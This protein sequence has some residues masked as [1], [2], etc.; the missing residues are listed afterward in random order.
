MTDEKL[1]A[2]LYESV[3]IYDVP[4]EL[5]EYEFTKEKALGVKVLRD[6]AWGRF[7]V[8]ESLMPLLREVCE[9]W[10]ENHKRADKTMRVNQQIS[11]AMENMAALIAYVRL[12]VDEAAQ[13]VSHRFPRWSVDTLKRYYYGEKDS[14]SFW[15]QHAALEL[16]EQEVEDL[17]TRAQETLK[18][19]DSSK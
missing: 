15:R 10:L 18:F 4:K 12:S 17:R 6:M 11:F 14:G 19:L 5:A 1:K 16:T 9:Y 7:E 2:A 8:E 3:R 13:L